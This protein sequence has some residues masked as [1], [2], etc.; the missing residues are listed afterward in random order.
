MSDEKATIPNIDYTF[1]GWIGCLA[2]SPGCDNCYAERIASKMFPRE[3]LWESGATYHTFADKHWE[4]PFAWERRGLKLGRRL[5]VFTSSMADV[6]DKNAPPG[7]RERLFRLMRA[8]PFLDWLIITKRIGNAKRMLPDDWGKGY[9]NVWLGVTIV[10]QEEA[11]RD[12]SKLEATPAHIRFLVC[13]PLLGP[14]TFG[15]RSGF[16]AIDWVTVG[17]ESGSRARPMDPSWVRSIR[18][19][20][21][22]AAVPFSFRQGSQANWP[23]FKDP[24][25]FP[26]DL[27]LKQEP[28]R[29]PPREIQIPLF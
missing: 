22:A 23:H 6:F 11:D 4:A 8:T 26:S 27:K 16:S 18:D 7:A 28:G 13:E 10:N 3:R 1:N 15:G 5:R 17:G 25:F 21:L 12:I 29:A 9:A 19:E 14:V 24:A 20:C 2:V